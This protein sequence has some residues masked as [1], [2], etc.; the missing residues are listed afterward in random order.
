MLSSQTVVPDLFKPQRLPDAKWRSLVEPWTA[1]CPD[2]EHWL[3]TTGF[4][5]A[6]GKVEEALRSG[7]GPILMSGPT[8]YGKTLLLRS[9]RTLAPSGYVPLLIPFSNVEP[10]E[11]AR[12]ILACTLKT[13]VG[14]PAVEFASLLK[15]NVRSGGNTLLLMDEVQSTPRATLAKLFE[16]LAESGVAVRVVLAGLPGDDLDQVIAE[17]PLSIQRIEIA[18]PWSRVDAELLLTHVAL[19]LGIPATELIATI[20]DFLLCLYQLFHKVFLIP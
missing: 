19:T 3:K 2:P 13:V 6:R 11:I 5:Y 20:D 4:D 15:V 16:L 17:V 14:D 12:W 7:P 9:L 10:R 18:E 1:E 8:G